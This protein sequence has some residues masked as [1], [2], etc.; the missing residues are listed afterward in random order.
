[1]TEEKAVAL[2]V[3]ERVTNNVIVHEAEDEAEAEAIASIHAVNVAEEV[4]EAQ[5]TDA[6]DALQAAVAADEALLRK[7]VHTI[8]GTEEG[9][10]QEVAV[11]TDVIAVTA[12]EGQL[13]QDLHARKLLLALA[14]DQN[15]QDHAIPRPDAVVLLILEKD[16]TKRQLKR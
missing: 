7:A 12:Q 5:V 16:T 14:T 9:E 8:A 1:M 6:T 15:L 4:V 10:T 2:N 3:E 13:V 11:A